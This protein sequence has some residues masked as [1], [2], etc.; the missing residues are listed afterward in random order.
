V[1]IHFEDG[2]PTDG[3]YT[4][5]DIDPFDCANLIDFDLGGALVTAL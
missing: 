1:R 2:T 5:S 3:D 4:V